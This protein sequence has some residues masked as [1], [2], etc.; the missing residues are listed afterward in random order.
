[1]TGIGR[2]HG[3]LV[4]MVANDPTVK[5][6]TYYPI[7]VKV[8]AGLDHATYI[9]WQKS[10]PPCRPSGKALPHAEAFQLLRMAQASPFSVKISGIKYPYGFVSY[11]SELLAEECTLNCCTCLAQKHL[12]L[13][14]IAEM[15]RLPCVYFVDSGGANLPRQADVFPDR[16]HF[17]RIFYNQVPVLQQNIPQ[18]VCVM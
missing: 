7:T 1:M 2:V 3:R 10:M 13:Q 17:G 6:G 9:L 14:E 8:C 4:A 16:D 15:C 5:G 12:R 11:D 18:S